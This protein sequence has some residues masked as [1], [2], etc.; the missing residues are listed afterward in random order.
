M[1]KSTCEK[2]LGFK[3]DNRINFDTHVKGLSKKANNELS[4]LERA[5]ISFEKKKLL[6]NSLFNAQFNY[7]PL[8]W[9][10]HSRINNSKIKHLHDHCLRLVYNDKQS[11]YEEKNGTVSIHH[12]NLQILA[13]EM[14][15]VK[16]ELSPEIISDIFTQ[17]INNH[18]NL[19]HIN[20][21]EA[22]FVR[23][24][25]NETERVSYLGL[26]IWDIVPEEYKTLNSLNSFKESIK[27]WIPPR[28][29]CRLF[30]T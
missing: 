19:R 18:Y 17:R 2:F 1:K 6:M 22:T 4:A 9:M 25:Y 5:S 15:K 11:S 7:C 14:F 13:T 23:A 10:L 26:K 27:N 16:T 12:I 20:H 8:I 30:K 28:C 24:V 3:I 29:I 21:F